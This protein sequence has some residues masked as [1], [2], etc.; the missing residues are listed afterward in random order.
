VYLDAFV[1]TKL[2]FVKEIDCYRKKCSKEES[3]PLNRV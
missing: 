1:F 3:N 2:S